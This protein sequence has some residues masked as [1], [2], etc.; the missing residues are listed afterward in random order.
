MN[1]FKKILLSSALITLTS[2]VFAAPSHLTTV[3]NTSDGKVFA[4]IGL[5]KSTDPVAPKSTK[6]RKWQEVRF[7]CGIQGMPNVCSAEI[8]VENITTHKSESLGSMSMDLSSG[9]LTPETLSSE[10]YM[11]H[12]TGTAHVEVTSK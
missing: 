3:N 7:L 2:T 1:C 4:K 8:I 10:H 11:M 6:E 9:V 5:Y 12:V